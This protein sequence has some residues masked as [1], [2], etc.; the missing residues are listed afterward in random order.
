MVA[1][2]PRAWV[3]QLRL[4]ALLREPIVRHLSWFSMYQRMWGGYPKELRIADDA[5]CSQPFETRIWPGSL[6]P[7]PTSLENFT[8][9]ELAHWRT[10]ARAFGSRQDDAHGGGADA[11]SVPL[12][13][14]CASKSIISWGMYA[15]QLAHWA[16]L[17]ER[18]QLL[19]MQY[20]ALHTAWASHWPRLARFAGAP[21]AASRALPMHAPRFSE[22][23]GEAVATACNALRS[24]FVPW[25]RMLREWLQATRDG[26]SPHEPDFQDFE[27]VCDEA[28]VPV[29]G[30][31]VDR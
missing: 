29:A 31:V 19:V 22:Y 1:L 5:F 3:A 21:P 13:R 16:A 2:L 6:Q 12:Y 17:F 8:N 4:I 14:A 10:C 11:V 9:C 25:N 27:D 7:Y 24:V 15:P 20:A 28:D 30:S 18:S 26:R 23:R